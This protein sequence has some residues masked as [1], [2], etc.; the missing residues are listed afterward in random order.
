MSLTEQKPNTVI[1]QT[2]VCRS[3]RVDFEASQAPTWAL[4]TFT[5]EQLQ[6]VAARARH[7]YADSKW[8]DAVITR[9]SLDA[10]A[11]EWKAEDISTFLD[12]V[13]V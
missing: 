6:R 1:N 11:S 8:Q 7:L 2:S 13:Q 12:R 4:A 5:I 10:P 9:L 3:Q